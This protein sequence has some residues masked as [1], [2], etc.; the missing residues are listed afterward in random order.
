MVTGVPA[1][2]T[3]LRSERGGRGILLTAAGPQMN[4]VLHRFALPS[5]LR[6]AERWG[7]AVGAVD[8]PEDGTGADD[9]AQQAKWM[10]VSLLRD[11]LREFD[12]ALWMDADTLIVRTDEDVASHLGAHAFQALT[13]EQVPFDHRMNPNTGVWL[14]RSCAMSFR[15]LDAVESAGH[16]P[17]PWADQGAVLK[18]L[19][20]NRGDESY[21]WASPGRGSRF[22]QGTS[23]LPP[24]WN[25]SYP[26]RRADADVY[27]STSASYV[28]RPAVEDPCVLHFMGMK[29][30]ARY[31]QMKEVADKPHHVMGLA[32]G[33]HQ[34]S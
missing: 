21:R 26:S 32:P 2:R 23:W 15:F 29:P 13:L 18:V 27:N 31:R 3:Q 33:G 5:F 22:L 11:A 28:G 8:L 10:K 25:Q 7:Y 1:V 24:G 9:G 16:Q 4:A 19:G 17:G 20:W 34:E 6:Y 12:L 14:M 30:D